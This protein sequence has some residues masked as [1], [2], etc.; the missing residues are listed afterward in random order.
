MSVKNNARWLVTRY[1][2]LPLSLVAVGEERVC[3]AH[4]ANF[5]IRE[6]VHYA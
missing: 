4:C 3:G 5:E 1:Y 2:R 6:I